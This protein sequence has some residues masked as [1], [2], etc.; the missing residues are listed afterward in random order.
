MSTSSGTASVALGFA[1]T[2]AAVGA[3]YVIRGRKAKTNVISSEKLIPP[4]N[5]SWFSF[6]RIR[7]SS[8]DAWENSGQHPEGPNIGFES[9][10]SWMYSNSLKSAAK[11]DLLH[12]GHNKG[13]KLMVVMVGL[14][15]RG[16]T[17]IA[18]KVARYLRWISYRTRAFSIAKYRLD[19]LGSKS[20]DFFDMSNSGN[21]SQRVN[22]M[23]EALEDA[24]RYL[25][26][27]GEIAILDGTNVTRDRRDMI[28][29]RVAKEDGYDILWIESVCENLNTISDLQVE[30]LKNS[31]DFIDKVDYERRLAHYQKDYTTLAADEGSFVRVYDHGSTLTLNAIHGFL[32]TKIVAFVMNLKPSPRPIYIA[33]HGESVFNVRGLIGGDSS[34]SARGVKFSRALAEYIAAGGLETLK[35]EDVAVWTSTMLRAKETAAELKCKRLVEWRALREIEVGV[36]DGL[37]YEQIKSRFPEEYRSRNHDKLRYRYPRGESYLDVITRLEPVI[38]ELERQEKPLLIIAHQAVLRCLY[39]YFLDLPADE[40]PFLS[41][42]LHTVIRLEAKAY[43]CKEKRMRIVIDPSQTGESS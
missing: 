1:F 27:G 30:E 31:P 9:N 11:T 6:D 3:F 17:F 22:V 5:A 15:G 21:Y 35:T 34:L 23:V 43:G 4:R 38:Y 14:P 25:S 37:S 40:I 39:A 41:I 12:R 7:T 18:R 10:T 8:Q 28:R 16:K 42:P 36:C 32:P 2:V 20:A 29:Q 24:L 13:G 19:K 33:R 26:R